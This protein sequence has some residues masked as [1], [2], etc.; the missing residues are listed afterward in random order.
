MN[1][2]KITFETDVSRLPVLRK[3]LSYLDLNKSVI[4]KDTEHE[5]GLM[6]EVRELLDV[7]IQAETKDLSPAGEQV[8]YSETII[9][10][11]HDGRTGTRRKIIYI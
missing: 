10:E 1:I 4:P 3:E 11:V 8:D 9:R 2:R 7:I 6:D 5:E